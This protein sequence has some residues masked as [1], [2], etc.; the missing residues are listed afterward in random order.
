MTLSSSSYQLTSKQRLPGNPIIRSFSQD[1]NGTLYI[2]T[3]DSYGLR[4][5]GTYSILKF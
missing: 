1:K 3:S 2:M 4:G 5:N